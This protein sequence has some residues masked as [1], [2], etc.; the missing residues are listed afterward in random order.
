MVSC[1]SAEGRD[2]DP[3]ALLERFDI[4][5]LEEV[6]IWRRGEPLRTKIAQKHETKNQA[7]LRIPS[8]C[9]QTGPRSLD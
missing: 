3:D 7:R 4:P 1:Q 8:R 9:F 6:E 5:S 2:F